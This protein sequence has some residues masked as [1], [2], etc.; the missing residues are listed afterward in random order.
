MAWVGEWGTFIHIPKC[1]GSSMRHALRERYGGGEEVGYGHGF[2]DEYEDAWCLV[3]HPAHY[4]RSIWAWRTRYNWKVWG[5]EQT[6]WKEIVELLSYGTGM[7]WLEFVVET[8]FHHPGVV[9]EIYGLYEKPGVEF[10]QLEYIHELYDRLGVCLDLPLLNSNGLSAVTPLL[11]EMVGMI[12]A[13]EGEVMEKY[14]GE[15]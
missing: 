7:P 1:A 14:Y 3:K 4:L 15:R 2:P 10:Y 6:P 12:E 9:G 11:Q 5:D 13:A 8:C